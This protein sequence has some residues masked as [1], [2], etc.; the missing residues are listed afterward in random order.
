[1]RPDA[2]LLYAWRD[3]DARAGGELFE[4]HYAAI[5]HF[6]R[7]KV[8]GELDDLVQQTFSRCAS[9]RD[10]IENAES[11]RAFVYGIA[12][13]VLREHY[14]ATRRGEWVDLES[15]SV[16]DLG[17]SPSAMMSEVREHRLLLEALRTIPLDHQIAI[18]LFYWESMT[19]KEIAVVLSIP[20]G[21]AKTRLRAARRVLESR[22]RELADSQEVLQS[23]LDN[24]QRWSSSLREYLL[25]EAE[26]GP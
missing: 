7:D 13:N 10:R 12:R 6:F 14:K 15:V 21:T 3:G 5:Y 16:A 2:E 20:L 11:F 22:M 1:M 23:T 26:A 8:R 24:L 25:S 17:V 19:A 4:R 9:S 18:E